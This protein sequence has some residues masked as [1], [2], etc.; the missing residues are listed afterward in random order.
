M[1][2]I[3]LPALFLSVFAL[4]AYANEV[5]VPGVSSVQPSRLMQYPSGALLVPQVVNIPS[6]CFQMGSPETELGRGDDELMHRVCVKGFK[7]AKY[8]KISGVKT[9]LPKLKSF[10]GASEGWGFSIIR[11]SL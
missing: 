4:P 1:R 5:A 6:G 3:L 11:F 7:L 8:S 2:I 9:N 10:D